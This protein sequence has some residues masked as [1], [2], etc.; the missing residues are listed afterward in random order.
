MLRKTIFVLGIL[1]S[2]STYAVN[3]TANIKTVTVFPSG[4]AQ[5]ILE[6]LSSPNPAGSSPVCT[7]NIVLLGNPANTSLLS[8]ALTLYTTQKQVRIGVEGSGSNCFA[9][10]ISSK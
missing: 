9:S 6:N 5:I 10:Y 3:W 1:A 4:K 8:L 2:F 7:N